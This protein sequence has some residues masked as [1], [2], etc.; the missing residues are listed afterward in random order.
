[1]I[2]APIHADLAPRGH[3]SPAALNSPVE[4]E[5]IYESSFDARDDMV[6]FHRGQ[7]RMPLLHPLR[8]GLRYSVSAE[9]ARWGFAA[10]ISVLWS[11]E[12]QTKLVYGM[13]PDGVFHGQLVRDEL[14][15]DAD[16]RAL[17][18]LA[19]NSRMQLDDLTIA[20]LPREEK[21]QPRRTAAEQIGR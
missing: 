10:H 6:A 13:G 7:S 15:P 3:F 19:H 11:P 17:F 9:G 1:V 2:G 16:G 21:L 8:P 14:V 5:I 12:E 18:P 20:E 4:G